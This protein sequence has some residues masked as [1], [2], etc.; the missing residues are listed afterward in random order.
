[1]AR[2]GT[3]RSVRHG[4]ARAGG[5][6]A[7]A[8]LVC[9]GVLAS[10]PSARAD[11]ADE[12]DGG[13][14]APWIAVALDDEGDP[15]SSGTTT[16]SVIDAGA[17]DYLL[18]A[19]STKALPDGGGGAASIFAFV[20]EAFGDVAVS[21]DVNAGPAWGQQSVL[22]VIA[23]GDPE[24]GSAY[25]ATVDFADARFAIARSDDFIDAQAPL[26]VDAS[27]AIDP[28]RTYRIEFFLVGSALTARLLDASTHALLST[29]SAVD[30]THASGS[31]GLIVQTAYDMD[32]AP[33]APVVGTFDS[34]EVVPEP[35]GALAIAPAVLGLLALGRPTE[36]RRR[37]LAPGLSTP[38]RDRLPSPP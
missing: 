4:R 26:V 5:F 11:W 7:G 28:D 34:V 1:M 18:M 16:F 3:G 14:S 15:P 38:A 37:G 19:H 2:E 35:G 12:F 9:A 10:T 24:V 22:G 36:R 23:R 17:D 6:G 21:A 25:L 32:L 29:I 31:V 30:A 8:L 13:F 20:D 27:V 33:V